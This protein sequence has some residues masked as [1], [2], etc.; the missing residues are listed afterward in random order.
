MAGG[1]IYIVGGP[2]GLVAVEL[3]PIDILNSAFAML[4]NS[5]NSGLTIEEESEWIN[6]HS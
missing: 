5:P 1:V 6:H 2:C 3:Q 4:S